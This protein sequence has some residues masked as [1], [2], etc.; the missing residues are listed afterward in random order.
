MS[1]NRLRNVAVRMRPLAQPSTEQS[2]LLAEDPSATDAIVPTQRA[3]VE[4]VAP[5]SKRQI[6]D[7]EADDTPPMSSPP[8]SR[9]RPGPAPLG[10]T[11]HQHPLLLTDPTLAN[12]AGSG[13]AKTRMIG[14]HAQDPDAD[15]FGGHEIAS[16]GPQFPA[17]FLIV[18]EGPGRGAF[19]AVTTRVSSIGRGTDQDVALDFG[20]ESISRDGHASVVYD[21]EQNQFYLGQGNKANVV[22]RNGVPVLMTEELTHNDTIRIGKTSLRFHAFCGDDFTWTDAEAAPQ[23]GRLHD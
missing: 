5:S 9:S 23:V 1:M 6:W 2:A 3:S 16:K 11:E 18:V 14:F 20:D 4:D 21:G 19:F 17:G 8:M 15:A 7:V 13:R 22:R 10:R 12:G